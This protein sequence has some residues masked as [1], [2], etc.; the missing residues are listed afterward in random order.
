MSGVPFAGLSQGGSYLTAVNPELPRDEESK[1]NTAEIAAGGSE[2][3]DAAENAQRSALTVGL[4]ILNQTQPQNRAELVRRA[5][6]VAGR[7]S[8]ASETGALTPTDFAALVRQLEE[9]G[10]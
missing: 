1:T 5:M 3:N 6:E 10:K 4:R 9:E 2:Q 7:L 8:R